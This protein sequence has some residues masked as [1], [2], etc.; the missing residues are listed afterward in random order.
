MI[1]LAESGATRSKWAFI[2]H[3]QPVKVVDSDGYNPNYHKAEQLISVIDKVV[4]ELPDSLKARTIVYY[5]SGCAVRE[6]A[7]LVN[8]LL[9]DRFSGAR[10]SVH[11]D[12]LAAAHGLLGRE[13]GVPIILGTGSN[14]GIYN[15]NSIVG[16]LPSLGYIMGDEGSGS[17]LGRLLI[18]S[19]MQHQMPAH[20]IQAFEAFTGLNR[21][22]LIAAVYGH[23]SPGNYLASL[24]P[25]LSAN[26]HEK[27]VQSIVLQS[28]EDF[29]KTLEL[30]LGHDTNH[31]MVAT[32]SVAA[33]FEP[34]LCKAAGMLNHH[35][36]IKVVASPFD[37]LISYH[38]QGFSE[39]QV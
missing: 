27:F 8:Q 13:K 15:G 14:A 30:F 34:I 12:L 37:G 23:S 21:Q 29:F 2:A 17:H 32:G 26:L 7:E 33:V 25:F 36:L 24:A 10:I 6:R 38:L 19:F 4:K 9:S 5:G 20:L 31:N 1:L 22:N 16:S 28:F 18:K 11:G 39:H 35:R 3:D